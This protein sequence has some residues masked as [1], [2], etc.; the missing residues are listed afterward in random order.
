MVDLKFLRNLCFTKKGLRK[1]QTNNAKATSAHAKLIKIPVKPKEARPHIPK[2]RI[3]ITRAV[4][5]PILLIPSLKNIFVS[6]LQRL[7]GSASQSTNQV[8]QDIGQHYLK[9]P[10]LARVP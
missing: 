4:D 8:N 2:D 1:M 10:K 3:T 7:S 6:V 9:V 5:L